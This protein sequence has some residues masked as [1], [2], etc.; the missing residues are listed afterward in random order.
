MSARPAPDLFANFRS[1]FF[2]L[3][4]FFRF[5]KQV[6]DS[7]K[8]WCYIRIK[9]LFENTWYGTPEGCIAFSSLS[10]TVINTFEGF[11]DLHVFIIKCK[12]LLVERL[13]RSEKSKALVKYLASS[14]FKG[15]VMQIE[16]ALIN[17]RLRVSKVSWKFRIQNI[18]NFLV[19]YPW[20][21]LFS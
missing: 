17:N 6:A 10:I 4:F 14:S 3:Y 7:P 15:T 19:I 9:S 11:A 13:L 20:N 5:V 2:L 18:Y 8:M 16:K 12:F 1:F 21:L